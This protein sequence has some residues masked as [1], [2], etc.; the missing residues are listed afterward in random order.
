MD[1]DPVMKIHMVNKKKLRSK[2][3]VNIDMEKF[4]I[5]HKDIFTK[6]LNELNY[7]I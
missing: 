3:D 2:P 1:Y 5:I 6:Q 4:R 7:Q